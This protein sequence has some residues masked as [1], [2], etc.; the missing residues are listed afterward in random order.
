MSDCELCPVEEK[1]G[2]EFKPCDCVHR[3]KFVPITE[4]PTALRGRPESIPRCSHGNYRSQC[5]EC[6][7]E[8]I[9]AMSET[10]TIL[11]DALTRIYDNDDGIKST[12]Q[13]ALTRAYHLGQK[14]NN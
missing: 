3:R 4:K 13:H 2:Y 8:H 1:C 12:L 5:R 14:S 9:N 6:T 11:K 7:L 10:A